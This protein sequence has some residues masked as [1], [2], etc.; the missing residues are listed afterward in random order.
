MMKKILTLICFVLA[1]FLL[2]S[3]PA[4]AET[5]GDYEY[6]ALE[7]G[8]VEITK[9]NGTN[10]VVNIPRELDGKTVTGIGQQAF[11][12]NESIGSVTIPD[13]VKSIGTWAFSFCA[14]LASVTIPYSC[15]PIDSSNFPFA[16]CPEGVT[17]TF[18]DGTDASQY[19]VYN[20]YG[21][22]NRDGI[23][24]LHKLEYAVLEDG[25]AKITRYNGIDTEVSIPAKLFG[26]QVT[27]IK[28]ASFAYSSVTFVQIP[29]GVTEIE[30]LTFNS[31][32]ALETIEVPEGLTR[33]GDS[34]FTGCAFLKELPLREGLV[35]IGNN[36]F[37]RCYR[38]LPTLTI[39]GS[40]E[41]IG[42]TAF[43]YCFSL[44]SV[45]ISDG[46]K[47]IGNQAF[48]MCTALSSVTIPASV[49]SIGENAFTEC[50]EDLIITVVRG[51]YAEQYC[52][53]N[54]L[55]YRYD[56][57]TVTVRIP[58]GVTTIEA[59]AFAG[60]TAITAVI[61]PDGVT[62][63]GKDAFANCDETL[64]IVVDPDSYAEQYC[65]DNGLYYQHG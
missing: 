32:S 27:A 39:P 17:F 5:S 60:D 34:S 56:I 25:T 30:R 36:A 38:L 53:D 49:T 48:N 14:N 22:Y 58:D 12:A 62:S 28:E 10:E 29:E 43:Q 23:G 11:A 8:T 51:S 26:K 41:S 6:T 45:E 24:Y 15:P 16:G 33:I 7:D 61:I 37:A 52:V 9:Y 19:F 20:Y 2:A 3:V 21:G 64:I 50:S 47:T 63:I 65:I 42:N 18:P 54:D 35:S 40:V 4:Y 59:E 31:C 13:S 44:T 55:P 57:G 1:A 46:V